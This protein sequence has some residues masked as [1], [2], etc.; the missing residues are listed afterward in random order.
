MASQLQLKTYLAHW[1]Q[2]GKKVYLS[3]E[4]GKLSPQRVIKG[5]R[6]SQEFEDCW[7]KIIVNQGKD[8]YLEGTEQTIEEL[9][10]STWTITSCS[11]CDMP[12][13]ILDLGVQ[14]IGC[15]CHDIPEWPNSE[16]PQ[17]RSPVNTSGHLNKI[18]TRLQKYKV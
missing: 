11:R 14:P 8:C 13:P 10:T 12:V 5:D 2:L 4:G 15:P 9:L 1:F 3:K 16:L 7:Q 6:Y 18:Q 17:P